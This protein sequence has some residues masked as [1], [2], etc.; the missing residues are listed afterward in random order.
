[1]YVSSAP[2]SMSR[3]ECCRYLVTAVT[4]MTLMTVLYGLFLDKGTHL[5]LSVV[6]FIESIVGLPTR[7][8]GRQTPYLCRILWPSSA[9]S[10]YLRRYEREYGGWTIGN[11][12][13]EVLKAWCELRMEGMQVLQMCLKSGGVCVCAEEEGG[14]PDCP[15]LKSELLRSPFHSLRSVRATRRARAI[16]L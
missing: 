11:G 8:R 9:L 16:R 3:R 2:I 12:A 14:M 7:T 1:M 10:G 15:E 13:L 6:G 5:Y 4:A